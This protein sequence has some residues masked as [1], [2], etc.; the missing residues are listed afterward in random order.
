MQALTTL[1]RTSPEVLPRKA[2]HV[3][4]SLQLAGGLEIP[5][6]ATRLGFAGRIPAGMEIEVP[7]F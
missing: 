4:L 6:D 2:V 5:L 1:F 7:Q 3:K